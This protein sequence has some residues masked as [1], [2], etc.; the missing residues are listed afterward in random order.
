[1]AIYA[2]ASDRRDQGP[3]PVGVTDDYA[4]A[5]GGYFAAGQTTA[6]MDP[7]TGLEICVVLVCVWEV[8]GVVCRVPRL[9]SAH[10]SAALKAYSDAHSDACTPAAEAIM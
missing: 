3:S 8:H 2:Q 10:V 1:M 7:M 6:R 5:N 4:A 9:Q